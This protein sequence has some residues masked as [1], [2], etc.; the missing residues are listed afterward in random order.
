MPRSTKNGFTLIEALLGLM[1]SL[2]VAMLAVLWLMSARTLLQMDIGLQDQYAILQL[3]QLASLSESTDVQTHQ[4]TMLINH[5]EVIITEDKNRLVRRKGYE[6]FLEHI[7][8]VE[9]I[10]KDDRIYLQYEKAG[11]TYS[12]QIV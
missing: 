2:I 4:L 11:H 5:E 1:V 9:F 12:Y 6:I 8:H 10:Q 3:R 7:Q